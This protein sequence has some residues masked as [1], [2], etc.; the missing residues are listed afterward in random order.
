[1][2]ALSTEA[3]VVE[4]LL[5]EIDKNR[6]RETKERIASVYQITTLGIAGSLRFQADEKTCKWSDR[7]FAYLEMS[8]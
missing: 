4:R 5:Q 6:R 1:M 7:A 3:T 2:A 8:K